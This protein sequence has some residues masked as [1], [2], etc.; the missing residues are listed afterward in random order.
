MPVWK[1]AV[2]SDRAL[3][4]ALTPCWI[5][6]NAKSEQFVTKAASGYARCS[7]DSVIAMLCQTSSAGTSG[8]NWRSLM[9]S[10]NSCS[11]V[12]QNWV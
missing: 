9:V 4:E 3:E 2:P 8:A 7:C 6:A 11:C 12:A 1:G 5:R 10:R